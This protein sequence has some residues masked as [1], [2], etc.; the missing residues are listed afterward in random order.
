MS[1]TRTKTIV[2]DAL[3]FQGEDRDSLYRETEDPFSNDVPNAFSIDSRLI[4]P[5]SALFL[6]LNHDVLLTWDCLSARPRN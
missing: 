4:V 1:Q 3:A 5:F 6:G 2:F